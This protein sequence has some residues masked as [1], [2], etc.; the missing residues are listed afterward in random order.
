MWIDRTELGMSVYSYKQGVGAKRIMECSSALAVEPASISS[1]G[2]YL[3]AFTGLPSVPFPVPVA[4]AQHLALSFRM[5]PF[6]LDLL[7]AQPLV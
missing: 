5:L 6:A 2:G 3:A 4:L 1:R 7:S